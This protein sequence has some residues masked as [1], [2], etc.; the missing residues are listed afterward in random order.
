MFMDERKAA[1]PLMRDSIIKEGA[2]AKKVTEARKV[3]EVKEETQGK[4]LA[5]GAAE[6]VC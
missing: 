5:E 4:R 6:K 1:R 3:M 2:E